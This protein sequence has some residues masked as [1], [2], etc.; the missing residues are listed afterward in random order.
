[1]TALH[2]VLRPVFDGTH[3]TVFLPEKHRV[4]GGVLVIG[5]SG[6]SEPTYVAQA[7]AGEGV[8]AMSVAYFARPGLP[9]ELRD[10]PLEYFR[11]A[12]DVLQGKLASPGG[13][14]VLVGM[15]R[16]SEAALLS[17]IHFNGAISGVVVTVPG[18]LVAGSWPSGGA[19]WLLEGRPL[20]YAR[21]GGPRDDP[22][23]VIPAERVPGPILLISAGA[24]EVWPSAEMARAIEAR[25]RAGAHSFGH[26]LLEYPDAGHSL[27]YLVPELPPGLRSSDISDRAADHS[28]RS[29]AW[30][31]IVRFIIECLRGS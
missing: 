9:L 8:A 4:A 23:A 12:I 31:R 24:D 19:A 30:P 29:D 17:A 27:G 22:R 3:G 10:I 1:M 25:L 16:G 5:G 15:S 21:E 20:S 14:V 28:A 7:L 11:H 6:G 2:Y 13:H 26:E 18:N